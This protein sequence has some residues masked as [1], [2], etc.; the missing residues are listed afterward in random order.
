MKELKIQPINNGTVIDHIKAGMGLKVLRILNI[1]ESGTETPVSMIMN[2]SG[3]RERKKDI[4]K[5]EDRELSSIEVNK[6]AL[7]AP[8]ATINIIR[9][10]EVIEK[11]AV[12]LPTI[13]RGIVRCI[14]PNCIS[15][16][17]EPIQSEFDVLK[18]GDRIKLRCRYCSRITSDLVSQMM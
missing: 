8:D 4:V 17:N 1:E 5:V 18:E 9:N 2:V 11:R 6:I 7:V 16:T 15:N 13:I 10:F 3:K 12:E 14:N